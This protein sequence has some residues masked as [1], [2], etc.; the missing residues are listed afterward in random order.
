MSEK[1]AVKT[2][3][4]MEDHVKTMIERAAYETNAGEAMKF[5]QAA[6]NAA[7]AILGLSDLKNRL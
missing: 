7:N 4:T 3:P 2:T 6:L 1:D 5:A